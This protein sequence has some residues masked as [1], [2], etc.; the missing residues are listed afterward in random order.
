[1]TTRP[2]AGN[3]AGSARIERSLAFGLAFHRALDA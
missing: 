3:E 1:M 2:S